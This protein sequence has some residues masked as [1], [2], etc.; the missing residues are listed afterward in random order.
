MKIR[1]EYC[2]GINEG[3]YYE[4]NFISFGPFRT[5]TEAENNIRQVK[6]L[7]AHSKKLLIAEV[8]GVLTCRA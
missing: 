8:E 5:K 4:I 2:T 3:W 1:P 6:E 7:L